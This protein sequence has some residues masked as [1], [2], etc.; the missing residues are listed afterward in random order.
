MEGDDP[1]AAGPTV[2]EASIRRVKLSVA[3]N[4]EI[5]STVLLL[6]VVHPLHVVSFHQLSLSV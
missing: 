3:S 4:E 6:V 2:P 5:G 1:T